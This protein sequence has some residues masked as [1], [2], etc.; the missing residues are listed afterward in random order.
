MAGS[1]VQ[2][3]EVFDHFPCWPG[4][5]AE[6]GFGISFVGARFRDWFFTLPGAPPAESNVGRSTRYPGINEEYVEWISLLTAV[7]R[8]RG[9][10]VMI[11]LGAGYGRWLVNAAAAARNY[12]KVPVHLVGVEAEPSHFRWMKKAFKDNGLDPRDHWLIEAAVDARDGH[13]S[14]YVGNPH[15]WY[16]QRIA[17]S[18]EVQAAREPLPSRLAGLFRRLFGHRGEGTGFRKVRAVSLNSILDRL[19]QVDYIDA[20][21]QGSEAT[22]FEASA[23]P[24]NAKVKAVHIG[25]HS[26]EQ[27]KRLRG[28]F[29]GLGW[30]CRFDY[31]G[32]SQAETPWGTIG[33]QDGA[34]SWENPRLLPEIQSAGEAA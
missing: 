23:G 19:Q 27:E 3:H 10:F 21:I 24:L 15:H 1:D 12:A 16:G 34:Q 33:F 31:P 14:F 11:E 2:H 32:D 29:T 4:P 20:D 18:N 5:A 17:E 8:A 30:H 9:R 28:L 26:R 13:V 6:D 25:T 7:R 22:V